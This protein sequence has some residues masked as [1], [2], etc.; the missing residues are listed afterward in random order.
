MS[1]L[2]EARIEI[3]R[4]YFREVDAKSSLLLELFT[5][6]VEFFFPKFGVARGKAALARFA[7][8]IA[9]DAAQLTHD[10]DGLIFTVGNDRIVVEGREWGVTADG[11][12]WPDGDISQGRFANVFEFDGL[13]IKRTFIYV[14][15]DFTSEDHRRV[16]MYRNA[17]PIATPREIASC[18]FERWASLWAA[19]NDPQVLAMIL[20]LFAEDVDWDI[21]GNLETVPW[22]GPR[23]GRKAVGDFHTELTAQIAPE[24]FEIQRLLA[25][26]E[27]AV[28]FGE[29]TSQVKAT[30]RVIESPFA[31]ILTIKEGKIVRYRMLEDSHAVAMAVLAR[32]T[33]N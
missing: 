11:K 13:L 3:I 21:P 5:D 12:T 30:G 19:P 25:D 17:L 10:I 8:R 20:E 9:K 4:R 1:N 7:E 24:R 14:D 32:K 27:T 23:Y 16:S 15:P 28:A 29:L 6:D 18:Y 31:F 2:S 33:G 22:I 26:D